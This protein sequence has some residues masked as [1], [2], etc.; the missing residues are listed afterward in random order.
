MSE[1][2]QKMVEVTGHDLTLLRY[3]ID[4]ADPHVVEDSH[5]W[6]ADA[7]EF[8]AWKAYRASQ[9]TSSETP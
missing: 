8:R 2:K 7:D 9:A 4:L 3:S 5:R 1:T 6:Y